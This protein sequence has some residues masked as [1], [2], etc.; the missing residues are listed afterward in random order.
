MGSVAMSIE[1]TMDR[2][3][4]ARRG[5]RL[6]YFTIA[7]N[8]MEGLVALF[9]GALAGSISLV[10]FG[11]DSFI[12]VA[13]GAALLWRM[14]VDADEERREKNERIALRVV[15]LCFL[16]LAAYVLWEAIA[17]L[18]RREPPEHSVPGIAL[19]CVSLIVMP[20]LSRAKRGVGHAM[21][22]AAMHADAKQTD[23]CVYLS[24][25]LL[26]GLLLNAFL[27]WWWADPLAALIMA[28]IIAREG[29]AGIRGETCDDC[30]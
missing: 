19:A 30:R 13:S 4:L 10:G 20:L 8:V 23:F 9:A 25:I 2:S 12:E 17:D 6:E 3:S 29:W 24:A 18:I 5:R 7:W 11:V 26:A 22:S 28:P 14:S 1:L 16:A 21:G 27:G 15:G